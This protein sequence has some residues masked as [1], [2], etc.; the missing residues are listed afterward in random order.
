MEIIAFLHFLLLFKSVLPGK[1][2]SQKIVYFMI[3]KYISIDLK[4]S[5]ADFVFY[6]FAVRYLI[7]NSAY[8]CSFPFA[9]QFY[10]PAVFLL[11][12]RLHA[13]VRTRFLDLSVL[14]FMCWLLHLAFTFTI[15]PF[16][17][18]LILLLLFVFRY[19]LTS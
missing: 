2:N 10:L 16:L 3:F 15:S 19:S 7:L 6:L 13:P 14:L 11:I 5:I 8:L 17:V 9:P 12:S 4:Y 1:K 18:F